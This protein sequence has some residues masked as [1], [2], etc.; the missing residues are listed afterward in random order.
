MQFLNST[1]YNK[2][3]NKGINKS[4]L[5]SHADISNDRFNLENI[6]S[7]ISSKGPIAPPTNLVFILISFIKNSTKNGGITI[8][9]SLFGV[10]DISRIYLS[11]YIFT[12]NFYPRNEILALYIHSFINKNKL[13]E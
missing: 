5:F 11:D 13:F 9:A 12:I 10:L 6:S 1:F 3:N 4:N 2:D 7:H 8:C